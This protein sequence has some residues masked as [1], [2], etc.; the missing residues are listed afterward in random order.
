MLTCADL[1]RFNWMYLAY[2]V[3]FLFNNMMRSELG[4]FKNDFNYNFFAAAV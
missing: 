3:I 1:M 4:L 2:N